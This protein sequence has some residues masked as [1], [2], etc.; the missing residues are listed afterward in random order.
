MGRKK[1]TRTNSFCRQSKT[2]S[3]LSVL[4]SARLRAKAA[5]SRSERVN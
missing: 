5:E 1:N 2:A 3:F 4:R